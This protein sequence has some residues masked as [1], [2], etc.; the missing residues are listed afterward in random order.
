MACRLTLSYYA[1]SMQAVILPICL[2]CQLHGGCNRTAEETTRSVSAWFGR[3]IIGK[4]RQTGF[5]LRPCKESSNLLT[6]DDMITERVIHR[7]L[8]YICYHSRDCSSFSHLCRCR[9]IFARSNAPSGQD[10]GDMDLSYQPS[11]TAKV[12]PII[13]VFFQ[14]V[15]LVS[16]LV[17]AIN[18]PIQ[19]PGYYIAIQTWSFITVGISTLLALTYGWPQLYYTWNLR[20]LEGVS[21]LTLGMHVIIYFLV[22][23]S[24]AAQYGSPKEVAFWGR[25]FAAYNPWVNFI[26][27]GCQEGILLTLCF[28]VIRHHKGGDGHGD[29]AADEADLDAGERAPLLRDRPSVDT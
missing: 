4:W 11:N 13:S 22:A 25:Y 2:W 3:W 8:F 21:M 9:P 19:G 20:R 6:A 29:A 10:T 15:L 18:R 14:T 12:F 28:Y 5:A 1:P 7:L 17:M 24:L 26:I 16:S 23:A 27:V